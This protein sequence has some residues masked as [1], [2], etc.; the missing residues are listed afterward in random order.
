MGQSVGQTKLARNKLKAI[1]IKAA[2]ET[3]KLHDGGG[4]MLVRSHGS[5]RW[6]Y[7]YSF[8][9]RRRDMG[10]GSQEVVSLSQ[11]PKARDKWE[12]VLAS[13]DDPI[14][15]RDEE[16]ENSRR[17]L[18][19]SD[20]TLKAMIDIVFEARKATLRGEGAS[21]RWK[22]PLSTH[23]VP[24][25]GNKRMSKITAI[26]LR[27][28]LS[29]IWRT[30]H[31]T[32]KKAAERLHIV[33]DEAEAID[34]NCDPKTVRQ[35]TRMLGKV[36]HVVAHIK[37]TPWRDIPSLYQSIPNNG[38]SGTCLRWMILLLVR[39][40]GSRGARFSEIDENVWT[41]PAERMKGTLSTVANFRV[42]LPASAVGIVQQQLQ[43]GGEFLFPGNGNSFLSDQSLHKLL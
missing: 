35:A 18:Q 13:G 12:E 3:G 14:S 5:G 19:M 16:R 10:P 20:P 17:A 24:K 6:L 22:S 30:K 31:P 42:P 37:A 11:A 41:V 9:G 26:D 39:S 7:R 34:V 33:F 36:N 27:D 23:I 1:Q 21:G 43:L 38:G 25:L 4:L 28:A 40:H 32:A 15:K 29:P 8:L 2:A